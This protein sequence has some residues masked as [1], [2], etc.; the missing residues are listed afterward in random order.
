MITK[1][2][3][4]GKREKSN[5][6]FSNMSVLPTGS[7]RTTAFFIILSTVGAISLFFMSCS[8]PNNVTP[9]P[10]E[11]EHD[12]SEWAITTAP[13]CTE[14][15]V[16][17]RICRNNSTHTETQEIDPLG[18]DW[19]LIEGTEPTCTEKGSG[20]RKC[21]V[22]GETETGEIDIDP[23]AHDW[24]EWAETTAPTCTDKGEETRTCKHNP[25]HTDKRDIAP[26]GHDWEVIG[27][28]G[29]A[30]TCTEE[31]YGTLK[32]KVCGETVTGESIP[33]DP[34]AHKWGNW[35]E[36][37]EP[38]CTDKGEETRTCEHN[39]THTEK[40]DVDPL[41]HDFGEW[42][43]KTPATCTEA[44]TQERV[45]K[46]NPEHTETQD[47][48]DAPAFDHDWG[49][50]EITT[51]P[52]CTE[53]GEQTRTCGHDNTHI[54]K[55]DI[56]IDPNNHNM[57]WVETPATETT[58]GLETDTC[59]RDCG[60]TDGT[61][62]LFAT[63]TP[64]L[65]YELINGDTAY[66]VSSGTVT[67][68][69]VFIPAYIYDAISGEYL[70][71]KETADEAFN[72]TGITGV[73]FAPNSE[74]ETISYRAFRITAITSVT[75]PA[76]VKTIGNNAFRSCANLESVTFEAG[77]K[78]ET[79]ANSAFDNTAIKSVIIPASV[80][81]LGQLAFRDCASLKSVIFED[82]SLLETIDNN[83]FQNSG[84]TSIVLPASVKTVNNAAFYDCA[85]LEIV[86]YGGTDAAAWNG[87][88]IGNNNT[89]LANNKPYYYHATEP[90]VAGRFWRY[91]NGMPTIW[92]CKHDFQWVSTA[93][94][95]EDG[96][97]IHICACYETQGT[98]PTYATGTAGLAFI[99][100]NNGTAYSVSR[101]T[102][103]SGTVRIPAY[104]RP[105]VDSPFMPVTVVANEAFR[106]QSGITSV[107]FT[108]GNQLETIGNYAFSGCTNIANITIPTSVMSIGESAF[109]NCSNLASITIPSSVTSIG[110]NA[111]NS[112][113]IFNSAPNNSVVYADKWAVGV[114]GGLTGSILLTAGTVGIA[115]D[116]L[117]APSMTS[118]EVPASVKTIG[119][120]AFRNCV[121]LLSV[122]FGANSQLETIGINAF[123][124]CISLSSIIIPA[125]VKRIGE[126]AFD[127]CPALTSVTFAEDSQLE[128]IGRNAFR[129][130]GI[131]S[132]R[133]PASVKTIGVS[134]FTSCTSLA[135]V[136][137]IEGSQLETISELAFNQTV[138]TVIVIPA[139]VKT[140]GRFAFGTGFG[141]SLEAVFF[142][143][144]DEAAW[145]SISMA[146]DDAQLINATR[147]Y[148][149]ATPPTEAG[150]FWRWVGG[151]PT[152]WQ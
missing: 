9:D 145:S 102:V 119:N 51:E 54:E 122:T 50:W 60:H 149:S 43:D 28:D 113:A 10:C 12:W 32:C 27:D 4:K 67:S 38:T 2:E 90:S 46:H 123:E 35:I 127:Y 75:I 117:G 65:A 22:C 86:Y 74:L 81:T 56:N 29:K 42:A 132:I 44:G 92:P 104:H 114:R 57:Q 134:A 11:F 13:T 63:G 112:T 40:V 135:S 79:I 96:T 128:T 140:I 124:G 105:N 19:E 150:N 131:T 97:E 108:A 36:T 37:T 25:E 77:S 80:K 18:H 52:T 89:P 133:I 85:D 17:T 73:T 39:N 142:G 147:Y 62:V 125:S 144:A 72:Q 136:T 34:T 148:Y 31:G 106:N 138:I 115:D 55:S 1:E 141:T 41:G 152:I 71:V 68:G 3:R 66:S 110:R 99:L 116:A 91:E 95:T 84:I 61:R 78:I 130:S 126:G 26:L 137:F 118:I 58:D 33:I 109:Q 47:N 100:S 139:S 88:T 93:T 16:E 151:V 7:F 59:M 53:K 121:N 8:N 45:C 48:P 5:S 101:G 82:G 64:G 70:P 69:N 49:N 76:S 14:N 120:N 23:N 103:T 21:K 24:G 143:G 30:P 146:S 15:G 6:E 94:E 87:I 129:L 20:T 111:F 98:R 107:T 83:T